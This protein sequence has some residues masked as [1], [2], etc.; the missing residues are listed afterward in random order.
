M[1]S[2]CCCSPARCSYPVS[3]V[4]AGVLP[5]LIDPVWYTS[6]ILDD[7]G[8]IGG[9]LASFTGYRARPALLPLIALALYW[10]LVVFFLNRSTRV[11]AAAM[12]APVARAERH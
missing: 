4:R 7:S 9:L 12:A 1:K 3:N 6:E 11:A 8:R 10:V 5:Q 2:C